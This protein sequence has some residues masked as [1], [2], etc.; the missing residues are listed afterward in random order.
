MRLSAR[1][2]LPGT[3]IADSVNTPR[4]KVYVNALTLGADGNLYYAKGAT[5]YRYTFPAG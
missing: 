1:N 4:G 5:I 3:V 2:Q